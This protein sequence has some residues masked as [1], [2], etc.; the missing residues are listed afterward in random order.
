MTGKKKKNFFRKTISSKTSLALVFFLF[1]IFI[2]LI[3]VSYIDCDIQFES[4][5]VHNEKM[6]E[7]K[8]ILTGIC[9][10]SKEDEN[11]WP[12]ALM[13]DNN[14]D[15]WP[16]FGISKADLVYS[17]L[18]EGGAT[19]FMA[20]FTSK[21]LSKI[22]P[23]RSAR[24]YYLTWAKGIDALYGH[25]GGS[26]EAIQKIKEYGVLN[27]EE[28]TNYGPKYFWRDDVGGYYAPHNLFTSS[29][30]LEKARQDFE[31]S[32]EELEYIK[33]FFGSKPT[34]GDESGLSININYSPGVLFDVEYIYSTSTN[35]YLRFQNESPHIDA[36]DNSQVSVKNL[37][38]QFVPK[39][40]HL[41]SEDRLGMET[42][43]SGDARIF[44]QGK[45]IQGKWKKD[46]VSLRTKFYTLNDK[47]IVFTPGNIW[48]EVVPENREVEVK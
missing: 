17:T 41:D 3:I 14:P 12:V 22:G 2:V 6:C 4:H 32:G 39:E 48:V 42:I 24:P 11:I 29:S 9:V 13:I 10:D 33:W 21:Q 26:A 46:S 19:R 23:V 18:V 25:S 16:Q 8:N 34:S 38:V 5:V 47:E 35:S 7:F 31:L 40:E 45:N 28:A 20:V 15:A 36:L 44:I 43:G 37:I 30:R 27:L 1:L